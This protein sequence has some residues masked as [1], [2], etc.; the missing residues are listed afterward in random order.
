MT[1]S[2]N[3]PI[4]I[5]GTLLNPAKSS[6]YGEVARITGESVTLTTQN[7]LHKSQPGPPAGS[8]VSAARWFM[9]GN[10]HQLFRF[11]TCFLHLHPQA[12]LHNDWAKSRALF[13]SR[14]T[15][16]TKVKG[17]VYLLKLFSQKYYIMSERLFFQPM[18]NNECLILAWMPIQ[19]AFWNLPY[20]HPIMN[21]SSSPCCQPWQRASSF[22]D[23]FLMEHILTTVWQTVKQ[24]K[25]MAL[26]P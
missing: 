21:V 3:K 18:D 11:S 10:R 14:P 16:P 19:V 2:F 15:T 9:F 4:T 8:P 5:K 24:T 13:W 23:L 20:I 1:S 6:I 7:S 25:Q 17:L 26:E 12:C 22:F